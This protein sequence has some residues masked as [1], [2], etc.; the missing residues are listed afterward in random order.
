MYPEGTAGRMVATIAMISG[1]LVLALPLSVIGS[2]FSNSYDESIK[3]KAYQVSPLDDLNPHPHPNPNPNLTLTTDP[4]TGPNPNPIQAMEE[5]AE[6]EA[7]KSTDG[8][9]K[10][11][12]MLLDAARQIDEKKGEIDELLQA[13]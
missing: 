13:T 12:N 3:A 9:Q 4:N 11:V 8:E 10:F 7:S 6:A 1:V 2:N 5:R